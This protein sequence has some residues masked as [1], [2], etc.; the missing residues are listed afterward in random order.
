MS[1]SGDWSLGCFCY[2]IGRGLS[3]RGRRSAFHLQSAGAGCGDGSGEVRRSQV[4][5]RRVWPPR[6][7][8]PDPGGDQAAS[9]I[10]AEKQALVQ[11]FVAHAAVE[12]L[13][14]AILHR[15]AGRDGVPFSL[16]IFRPGQ[17]GIRGELGAVIGDDH[18]E[19][20]GTMWTRAVEG[21]SPSIVVKALF[22]EEVCRT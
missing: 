9:M 5:E 21:T 14:E 6:V 19:L 12:G 7:E 10:E 16:V 11:Q 15:L 2:A 1:S 3:N 22:Q 18:A 13:D 17:D 20:S 4:A 8:V